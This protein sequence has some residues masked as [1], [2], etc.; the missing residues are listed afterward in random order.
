MQASAQVAGRQKAHVQDHS[1]WHDIGGRGLLAAVPPAANAG[2]ARASAPA[3]THVGLARCVRLEPHRLP[4]LSYCDKTGIF[5][6]GWET[7]WVCSGSQ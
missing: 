5:A 6:G 3:L 2:V 1:D 4:L 7:E